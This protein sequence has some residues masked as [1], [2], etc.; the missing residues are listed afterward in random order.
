[1]ADVID[2][3]GILY[4][5]Q[6]YRRISRIVTF[7]NELYSAREEGATTLRDL[8]T[9]EALFL[10]AVNSIQSIKRKERADAGKTWGEGS[11]AYE[12]LINL[13]Y[14]QEAY[15]LEAAL[16]AYKD[17][18]ERREFPDDDADD[19]ARDVMTMFDAAE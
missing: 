9:H 15:D 18:C 6:C 11:A 7:A 3:S 4:R 17:E 16:A 2:L 1:M 8:E 13:S 14:R 10:S 19:L 12:A 5:E